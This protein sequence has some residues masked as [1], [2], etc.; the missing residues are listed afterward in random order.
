MSAYDDVRAGKE[1]TLEDL[2]R[3]LAA[4]GEMT[5][6]SIAAVAGKGP[7]GV[8]YSGSFCPAA[9]FGHG[10]G[11]DADP[12]KAILEAVRDKSLKKLVKQLKDAGAKFGEQETRLDDGSVPGRAL[13]AKSAVVPPQPGEE[14][15]DS[16]FLGDA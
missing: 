4:R 15:D 5:H 16:A 1:A 6:L 13:K 11:R 7:N 10:F 12:V 8:V 14:I 9:Q 3:D 2:L